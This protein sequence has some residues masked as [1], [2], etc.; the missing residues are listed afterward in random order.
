MQ[1]TFKTFESGAGDCLFLILR[2][3]QVG[4][5]FHI[6]VDCNVLTPEIKQFIYSELGSKIDTLII[7]HIDADH[8][9][10]IVKLLRDI[11]SEHLQ[12][13]QILF[14]G[15]QPQTDNP[16]PLNDEIRKKLDAAM[17][18]LPP[19]VDENNHKTN[20]VDAA[21][22]VTEINKK[23]QWKDVWRKTPILAGETIALS[24]AKWGRLRFLSP[25][26]NA[27]DKLLHEVKLEYARKL[28]VAPPKQDFENQ[29]KYFELMLRLS[30]LRKRPTIIKK[31]RGL[32]ITKDVMVKYAEIDA[33]ENAVTPANKASLAFYW[34]STDSSKRVLMMGDAIPSQILSQLNE[35]YEGTMQFEAVKISHHG[36]KNNTSISLLNKIS[37]EHYFITGGKSSE[38][39][40]I[41]TIARIAILNTNQERSNCNL[42]Y[43]HTLDIELWKELNKTDIKSLL[44]EYHITLQT[45]NTHEFEY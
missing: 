18:F 39:P 37:S 28:G 24:E 2:D 23:Q 12:I 1:A 27:I 36:S 35:I 3:E 14:N 34:E 45:E 7:T 33:D 22:L 40:H 4:D 11:E 15:F 31:T 5:S 9:N 13:N 26:Q 38:G 32:V 21:C 41:E 42:H 30:N 29:D 10:G 17:K 43:N 20:G 16:Q 25:T 44:D 6:M 8:T 19:I